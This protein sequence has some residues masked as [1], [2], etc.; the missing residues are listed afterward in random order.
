[1]REHD[2]MFRGAWHINLVQELVYRLHM[3]GTNKKELKI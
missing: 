2:Q 3:V 1:M